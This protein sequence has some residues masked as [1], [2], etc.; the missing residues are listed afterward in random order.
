MA[1][2]PEAQAFE[3]MVI[4]PLKPSASKTIRAWTC[5]W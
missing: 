1:L 4:G 2:L 5:G 3:M